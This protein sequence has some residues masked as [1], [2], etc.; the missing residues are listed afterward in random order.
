MEKLPKLRF[1]FGSCLMGVA[2]AAFFYF[3]HVRD[4]MRFDHPREPNTA[5][6]FT[7]PVND[8]VV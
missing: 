5:S 3:A 1:V 6:G 2:V 8:K 4:A 7:H